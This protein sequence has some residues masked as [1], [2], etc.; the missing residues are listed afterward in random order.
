MQEILNFLER[1]AAHE[2]FL[3]P[4]DSDETITMT[5]HASANTFSAWAEIV[6]NNAV[7]FS[8]KLALK[9]GHISTV[10][11]ESASV[12]DKVYI[13]EIGYGAAKTVTV[14]GRLMS[15]NVRIGNTQQERIRALEIPAGET[16]YYRIKCETGGANITA[17][18]RYH[19]HD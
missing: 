13:Y 11:A 14:I 7:T 10:M 5:A 12:T 6:D 19:T 17:S 16:V 2:S 18:C 4:E 15:G 9:S 1:D 8:S 3:F